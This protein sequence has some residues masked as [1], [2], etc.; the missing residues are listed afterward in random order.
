MND[1]VFVKQNGGMGRTAASEDPISGLILDL[2]ELPEEIFSTNENFEQVKTGSGDAMYVAKL[3]YPEQLEEMGLRE[4]DLVAESNAQSTT[5]G[6]RRVYIANSAINA[7]LYH[8][9]EFFRMSPKGTLYLAVV[10][11]QPSQTA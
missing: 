3:R 9:R 5:A 1:I 11:E 8:V 10:F 4:I 7:T 6:A 2:P